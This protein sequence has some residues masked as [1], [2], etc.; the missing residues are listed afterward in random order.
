MDITTQRIR[1]VGRGG[2]IP[3]HRHGTARRDETRTGALHAVR[4]E[5]VKLEQEAR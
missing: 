1:A 2:N 5:K 3:A 4:L